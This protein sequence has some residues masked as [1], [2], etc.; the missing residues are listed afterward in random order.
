MEYIVQGV[1]VYRDT[2]GWS[3]WIQHTQKPLICPLTP[4][5]SSYRSKIRF[6]G[7]WQ[8]VKQLVHLVHV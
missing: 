4:S 7:V 6:M 1:Y 5:C 3:R 2:L 8:W